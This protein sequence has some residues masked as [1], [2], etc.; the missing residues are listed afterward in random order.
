MK[1][2]KLVILLGISGL[3]SALNAQ[4]LK[5][6]VVNVSQL[7][8][9]VPQA[10]AATVTL[11]NEFSENQRTLIALQSELQQLQARYETDAP[12]MAQDAR[13]T[14]E[15]ELMQAQ[16]DFERESA[17]FSEDLNIRRNEELTALQGLIFEQIQLFA[18]T[19]NFD[20]I[21]ADALYYSDTIDITGELLDAMQ[22]L[23]SSN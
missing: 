18:A 1:L 21:V 11:Q 10:Q 5:V 8:E 15:R 12:V 13:A 16:R 19:G 3:F 14:L 2:I 7:L 20:L 23:F 22:E 17:T 4:A 9:Q 6:G